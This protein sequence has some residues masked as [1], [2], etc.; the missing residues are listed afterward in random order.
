[1][2]DIMLIFN[3]DKPRIPIAYMSKKKVISKKILNFISA[4]DSSGDY[5]KII[6]IESILKK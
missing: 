2:K 5:S 4:N 6:F 3:T 1:M